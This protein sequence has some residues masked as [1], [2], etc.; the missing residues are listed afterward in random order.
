M[1]DLGS[2]CTRNYPKTEAFKEECTINFQSK[3]RKAESKEG[4]TTG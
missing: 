1:M 4:I 3:T 2:A